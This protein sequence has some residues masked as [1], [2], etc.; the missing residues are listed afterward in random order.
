MT[1]TIAGLLVV[2]LLSCEL[3][4]TVNSFFTSVTCC[5]MICLKTDIDCND[6]KNNCASKGCVLLKTCLDCNYIIPDKITP[7]YYTTFNLIAAA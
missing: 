4:N 1:K 5:K 2:L 6:S 3:G 7:S